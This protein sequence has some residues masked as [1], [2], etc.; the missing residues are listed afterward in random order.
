VI[1]SAKT[2][3]E[4]TQVIAESLLVY[5]TGY[6]EAHRTKLTAYD[7]AKGFRFEVYGT[8]AMTACTVSYLWDDARTASYRGGIQ[9][10]D[11]CSERTVGII[12]TC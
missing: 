11:L 7:K 4:A 9:A 12:Q 1:V 8:L 2:W 3:L 10:Y 5:T 6:L